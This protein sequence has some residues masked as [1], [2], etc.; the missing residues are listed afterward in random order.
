VWG[1]GVFLVVSH[2]SYPKGAEYQRAKK[3]SWDLY[4]R[5][6][7]MR[8]SNE[9]LRH[10]QTILKENFYSVDHACPDLKFY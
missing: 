5:A 3:D 8:N 9:A 10:D 4:K 7:G 6:Y 2:A 1:T